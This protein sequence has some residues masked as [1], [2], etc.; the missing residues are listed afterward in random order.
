MVKTY[1]RYE[2]LSTFGVIC[3]NTNV[4]WLPPTSV[5]STSAGLAVVGGLEEVLIWDIK[6]STLVSRWCEKDINSEVSQLCVDPSGEMMAAGYVDGSVRVWDLRSGTVLVTFNGHKSGITA[7]KFDSSGTRLASGS[8]DSNIVIWDLVGEVGLYR[9]RSHRDQVTALE[10]LGSDD[11]WL[12]STAKDGLIKLWNLEVQHCV[13]THVSHRGECWSMAIEKINQEEEHEDDETDAVIVTSGATKDLKFWNIYLSAED[14]QKLVEK[15][16]AAK[17]SP[18]RG[19]GIKFHPNGKFFAVSNADKS[20]EVW[21]RRTAQE[22]KKSV[23][24]K[25]KRRK[26]KQL[27]P[28]P[29]LS[30]NDVNE[31]YIP[32]TIIRT[33]AKVRNFDW[34]LAGKKLQLIVA[35]ANNTLES[36]SVST[37]IDSKKRSAGPAE[38]SRVHSIEMSGHRSDIRALS[39][40]SDNK[41]VISASNGSLKLWNIK[42]RNCLRTFECG[43]VLCASFLPGDA[44][45]VTGSKEG[46]LTLYDVA[47]SSVQE[48]FSAAHD[49]AIWS[50]D[51]SSDGKT[52][53]TA[54]A[55]KTVKFW[56]FRIVQDEVPG[57][58]RTVPRLKLKHV[59]TLE[60]SDDVLSVKLS[61][62][63]KLVAA[64]LLDN[65]IKVFF[66]AT[67]KFFLNLYGHKLPLLSLDI[68]D[69]SKLL[70]SCSADKNIKIWGM[71]FGDCHKSIFAHQDSVMKVV[72]EP[73]S[74]NFFSASK[75]RTVRYWDGDKFE[76]IQKLTGHHSEVW[77]LAVA[78]DA[79]F[80]VSGAH[81]RSIRVWE[82]TDEP[83]FLEEEREK[84]L[85]ELYEANLEAS[86]EDE[87]EQHRRS[88]NDEDD[89]AELNE[90]ERAG[91]QTIETLKAGEK[92][93]EALEIG[94]KDLELQREYAEI[95]NTNPKAAQPT[96]NIILR[97]LDVSPERYVMNV[98][99]K[100]KP[101]Q[102]EDALLVFPFD[103][104]V[105]LFRFIEI[106]TAKQW[107]I[108]L[109]CRVLFFT[110]RVHHKQ[111]VATKTMRLNLES[112][113]KNL[114]AALMTERDQVGFN[115]AALKYIKQNWD[116]NHKKEFLDEAEHREQE[117]RHVKKRIFTTV[118]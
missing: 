97:T 23:A 85:E 114:Q 14:G 42:S 16:T 91:K 34:S 82:L 98:L 94:I 32:Y 100:I 37:D 40:S 108:P 1:S 117:E 25:I 51:I 20:V 7:L 6:A 83:L 95:L 28:D 19:L 5:S 70:I 29:K 18:E 27:D 92:L 53:V 22:V 103:K 74:H 76:N 87:D 80:V 63:S 55:D 12:V 44:L 66:S 116:I 86:L 96:R 77:A 118:N 71:D 60:L 57:T 59:K 67:L 38:Y 2:A 78:K 84:E 13:E 81:D 43:Y 15:G 69:D 46:A 110:L 64:S 45:I 21:R 10:F 106:W 88:G 24:R 33:P 31:I 8:R 50:L 4:V 61:P 58:T 30:E 111:V 62:D 48:E 41:M 75:D 102:L 107:N 99:E 26:E 17:Q 52:M 90:V 49:G 36:Y 39:I 109:V 11:Q 3:S 9:L 47:S 89:A 35:L 68:S 115:I 72:F 73:N 104:V 65:T 101:S 79:S 56:E 112:L 105:S 93:M 54:S 113:N